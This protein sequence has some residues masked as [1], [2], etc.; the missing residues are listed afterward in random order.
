[1]RGIRL[2]EGRFLPAVDKRVVQSSTL[3]SFSI[4]VPTFNRRESLVR[5]LDSLSRLD[6]PPECFEVIVVNDGSRDDTGP[7]LDRYSDRGNISVVHI[8]N[9]GPAVARNRGA[10]KAQ[11][12]VI[13]FVD[14]DCTVPA[15]WLRVLNETIRSSG[16]DAVGGGMKNALELNL[17][18]EAYHDIHEHFSH[19][20]NRRRGAAPYLATSNFACRSSAFKD[21]GGFDERFHVGAED[22]YLVTRLIAEG[23]KVES[24]PSLRVNHFHDFTWK[25]FIR[26]YY[27][28]GKGASLLFR[29]VAREQKITPERL[30]LKGYM[31]L[32]G[33]MGRQKSLINR[34]ALFCLA[35]LSQIAAFAGY[36]ATSWEG[37]GDIVTEKRR[38]GGP[39]RIGV[40]GRAS[41]MVLYLGGTLGGSALGLGSI[42]LMGKSLSV[43]Q[44]GGFT[45]LFS[46]SS[47]LQTVSSTGVS[48]AVVRHTVEKSKG[49]DDQGSANMMRSAAL[50]FVVASAALL[51]TSA[52]A[53]KNFAPG[54]SGSPFAGEIVFDLFLAGSFAAMAFDFFSS[55]YAITHRLLRLALLRFTVSFVRFCLVL[56]ALVAQIRDPIILYGAFFLPNWFGVVQATISYFKG[57]PRSGRLLWTSIR[58]ISTY[59]GW[60]TVSG[61]TTVILQHAG[62][63]VL[64]LLSNQD[65]VGLYGLGL[66]FSFIYSVVAASMASYFIPIGMRLRTNEDVVEFVRR[67][68]RL[69]L[70]VI[71]LCVISLIAFALIFPMVFGS[72][73]APALPVFILLSISAILGIAM[74][75]LHGLFHYFFKPQLITYAQCAGLVST[76]ILGWVLSQYGA[77]GIAAAILGGRVMLFTAL[78]LFLK[79]EFSSRGITPVVRASGG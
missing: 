25:S 47:L 16:A 70:P 1:V 43:E 54:G 15:D 24:L 46:L 79:P 44:F 14:D 68:V 37:V 65:Q 73:K 10:E 38:Q 77:V 4:V 52:F 45:L 50:V 49:G 67:T 56:A 74:A 40:Q 71:G 7:M 60:Q 33:S 9:S 17:F 48:A 11:G 59:A 76:V 29:K 2:W 28:F 30:P 12:S 22:R 78:L 34:V 55:I 69:C 26:Q 3:L 21:I 42:L 27:R 72:E 57:V 13:A 31:R 66:T 41:E 6:Y 61:A 39:G 18:A 63:L 51:G 62:S 5:T 8:S 23:R 36:L 32:P 20:L 64:A 35:V 19:S 58:T 53:W 75:G